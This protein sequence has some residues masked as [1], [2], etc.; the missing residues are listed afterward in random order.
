M[1]DKQKLA[2][3]QIDSQSK[4]SIDKLRE[5]FTEFEISWSECYLAQQRC[6]ELRKQAYRSIG[7]T[8]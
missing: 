1:T 5:L 2:K 3:Q 8:S 7:I 6:V 4:K